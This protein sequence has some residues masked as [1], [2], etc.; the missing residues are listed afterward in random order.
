MSSQLK[1]FFIV[2]PCAGNG[3]TAKLWPKLASRLQLVFGS[4]PFAITQSRG[5]ATVLAQQ[6]LDKG[7]EMI[8][9]VGGDGTIHEV[10]N[11]F[12][13]EGRL[14][15]PNA[16]LGILSSGRGE[17]FIR[18]LGFPKRHAD[19]IRVLKGRRIRKV[20]LG[21]FSYYN[22]EGIQC[23]RYFTN[24]ADCGIVGEVLRW[25]ARCPKFFGGTLTYVAG[26]LLSFFSYR[27]K[28]VA[29]SID[30]EPQKEEK[31]C[32]IVVA[33]G[34][35]FG[36]GLRA[37]PMASVEDGLFDVL[38]VHDFKAWDFLKLLPKLLS[39]GGVHEAPKITYR[40]AHKL[41]I[42]SQ[43]Q[44]LLDADGES[45]GQLPATYEV[46]PRILPVKV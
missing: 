1:P 16:C 20:D 4:V 23:H 35:Y 32:A 37:A 28:T 29:L 3:R 31:I 21:R 46:V 5:H 43:E 40:T 22:S 24:I 9:A 44:V 18:T 2:N 25:A 45:L 34:Q 7:Y 27:N 13:H 14:R 30:D 26:G 41:R 6:A 39:R 15:Q 8:V 10:A 33:N 17:D 12:F 42:Y 36:G 11:G 19:Q 38:I